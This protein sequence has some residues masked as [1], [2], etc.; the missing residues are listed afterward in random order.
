LKF[1]ESEFAES[2]FAESKFAESKEWR[3][4]ACERRKLDKISWDVIW[5]IICLKISF[6]ISRVIASF[7]NT[8]WAS[9][10]MNAWLCFEFFISNIQESAFSS[11]SLTTMKKEHSICLLSLCRR[12]CLVH[13]CDFR[14]R[15]QIIY[16]L[17]LTFSLNFLIR[18]RIIA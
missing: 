3:I 1:A 9:T 12:F 15:S 6:L 14:S 17:H 18:N 10:M 13:S 2:E 4:A 8:E 7:L 11:A 5:T 16:A